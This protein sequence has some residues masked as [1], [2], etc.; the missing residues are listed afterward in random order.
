MSH[1]LLKASTG[2]GTGTLS[3]ASGLLV[4]ANQNRRSIIL[5]NDDAAIVV[6]LAFGV[7]AVL[8]AGL[9]LGPGQMTPVILDWAGDIFA[10]AAS[11][12]PKVTF[13]EV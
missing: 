5:C 4:A 1:G 12:T 8:N 6:Y 11:G 13:V 2:A 3:V 10:I 9:R 7:A